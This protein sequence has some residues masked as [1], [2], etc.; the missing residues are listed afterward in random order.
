MLCAGIDH[1]SCFFYDPNQSVATCVGLGLVS[2]CKNP[3]HRKIV[4]YR[5]FASTNVGDALDG[6]GTHVVGSIAGA[7]LSSVTAHQTW[8]S[9][10]N[11]MAPEA[12]IAFDDISSNGDELW[13]P[14]VSFVHG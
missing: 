8:A 12:K 3:A 9:D 13:L 5:Y 10:Y 2:N 4:T 14:D 6:H 11:G 1:D 7:A